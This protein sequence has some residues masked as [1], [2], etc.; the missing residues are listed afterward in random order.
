MESAALEQRTDSVV[1]R[2]TLAPGVTAHVVYGLSQATTVES[3]EKAL[4]EAD[5]RAQAG[6]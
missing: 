5:A 6:E 2:L 3:A 4:A 1:A